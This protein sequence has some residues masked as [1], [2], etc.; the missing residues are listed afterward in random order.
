MIKKYD[1]YEKYHNGFPRTEQPNQIVIHGTGGGANA[2]ALFNWIL[3]DHFERAAAYKG[4]EGFPYLVDKNGDVYELADPAKVWQ[5][6]SGTGIHDKT[7]IGIECVNS[8]G[9]NLDTYSAAQYSGLCKL[10]MHLLDEFPVNMIVGHGR[11]QE[12]L[13]GRGKVC[14]GPRFQW[15]IITNELTSRGYSYETS[16]ECIYNIKI[17]A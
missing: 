1:I 8:N 7:T 13:T 16:A 12:R 3:G 9:G 11:I 14:P 6:H 5:Y 2:Q 17:G 4:G 15:N 10:I